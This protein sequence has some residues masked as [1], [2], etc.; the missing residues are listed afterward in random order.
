MRLGEVAYIVDYFKERQKL[1]SL[2]ANQSFSTSHPHKCRHCLKI[3]IDG[4]VCKDAWSQ[5]SAVS[6]PEN[7]VT[8][9]GLV[10]A[11]FHPAAIRLHNTLTDALNAAVD[12][13]TFFEYLADMLVQEDDKLE[14][15]NPE[16]SD[17]H[18][19]IFCLEPRVG[20]SF[21]VVPYLMNREGQVIKSWPR[22][23][24]KLDVWANKCMPNNAIPNRSE[25]D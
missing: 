11:Q 21:A 5:A 14:P 25:G 1:A 3:I 18:D 7:P 8:T 9:G 13:C 19:V 22:Y 2:S 23:D 4:D 6:D 12:G 15:L 20:C 17:S 16:V 24:D 10:A